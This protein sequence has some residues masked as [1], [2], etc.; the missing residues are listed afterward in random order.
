[1]AVEPGEECGVDVPRLYKY[2][3]VVISEDVAE[4]ILWNVQKLD[5][6]SERSGGIVLVNVGLCKLPKCLGEGRCHI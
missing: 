3:E 6:S 2:H 4:V 5:H 1:M